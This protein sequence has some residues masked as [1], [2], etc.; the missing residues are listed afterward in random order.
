MLLSP[1]G[2][3]SL[4]RFLIDKLPTLQQSSILLILS[5]PAND[6]A[7]LSHNKKQ[8]AKSTHLV[9]FTLAQQF[10]LGTISLIISSAFPS[11]QD[12]E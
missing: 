7:Q 6:D 10:G 4:Q 5:G 1:S 9:Q 2:V 3:S 12:M 11:V 8:M